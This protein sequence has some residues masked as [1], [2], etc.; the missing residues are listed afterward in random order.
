M[1][2]SLLFLMILG[3]LAFCVRA[4]TADL[5]QWD[6]NLLTEKFQGLEQLE[7]F[8]S[9]HEET[10]LSQMQADNNN[11]LINLHLNSTKNFYETLNLSGGEP[12]LGIPS[13]M[14]GCCL[15]WV[16]ILIVSVTTDKDKA[17][18]KKALNG[19]IA[20]AIGS[21]G[22]VCLIWIIIILLAAPVAG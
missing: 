1:K 5:F 22:G 11:L 19:C 7:N 4:N 15:G 17:E 12:P 16:G 10:T 21:L 2:K 18:T 3:L 14:W 20:G 9:Q 13:F 8:V 6:E